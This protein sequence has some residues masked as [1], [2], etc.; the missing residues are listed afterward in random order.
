MAPVHDIAFLACYVPKEIPPVLTY[1]FAVDCVLFI[2]IC[3]AA[4]RY[5]RNDVVFLGELLAG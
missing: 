4:N 3:R 1:S 5:G 2:I